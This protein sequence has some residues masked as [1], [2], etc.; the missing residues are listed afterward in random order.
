M[1][2]LISELT[3]LVFV[4]G[5]ADDWRSGCH[6]YTYWDWRENIYIYIYIY[7]YMCVCICIRDVRY[8]GTGKVPVYIIFQ[9]V[10]YHNFAQFGISYRDILIY[11]D[12]PV[13]VCM[14]VCMC[15]CVC[16]CIHFYLHYSQCFME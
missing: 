5:M 4:T 13:Y 1:S 14:Y 6:K 15:V 16:V 3:E 2:V 11:W 8:T 9:T 7:I 12:A 10:R